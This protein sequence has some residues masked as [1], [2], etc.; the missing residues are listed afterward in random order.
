MELKFFTGCLLIA[1]AAFGAALGMV[2]CSGR[3]DV[4]IGPEIGFPKVMGLLV[5]IIGCFILWWKFG[6]QGNYKRYMV[7]CLSIALSLIFFLKTSSKL[8]I[9][10]YVIGFEH[11][12]FSAA[13]PEQWS[14]VPMDMKKSKEH[15]TKREILNGEKELPPDYVW[16]LPP[17]FV[18]KVFPSSVPWGY[19]E[20]K[21][22]IFDQ[23]GWSFDRELEV[24]DLNSDDLSSQNVIYQKVYSNNI[25]FLL[26]GGG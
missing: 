10:V 22:I 8:M 23:R 6:K 9:K 19:N 4:A 16:K 26:L 24:G 13:S 25:S 1:V 14:S 5:W 2:Y 3:W 7:L 20:D 11:A 12:V 15:L 17:D 18:W 21:L